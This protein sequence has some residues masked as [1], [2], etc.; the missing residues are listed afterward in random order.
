MFQ[1]QFC[2]YSNCSAHHKPTPEHFARHGFY[3]PKCRHTPVPRFRCRTCNR[4]YSRQSFRMDFRDHKPH[5]NV[6]LVKLL[7]S[8]VGLRQSARILSMSRRCVALK[9]RKICDHAAYLN[10]NLRRPFRC[11]VRLQMDE[12]ET[13]ETKRR[14]RPVTF[15][16]L[17]EA[18]SRFTIWGE[19]G[20]LRPKGKMTDRRRLAIEADIREFGERKDTS[21][22]TV[23]RTLRHAIPLVKHLLTLRVQ[24]DEKSTYP[25]LLK[26]AFGSGRIR[27]ETTSSKQ[28]RTI[29]NPLFPI[30][31]TEAIARDLNGRLRRESWLVSKQRKFL[32]QAFQLYMAWKNY[33]RPR[34]NRDWETPA[35]IAGIIKRRLRPGDLV[36]WRQDFGQRKLPIVPLAA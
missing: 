30:N 16:I 17:I 9:A 12:I 20:T 19:S 3:K 28:E 10:Q 1:P 2:P 34:F 25:G 32:D 31:Q 7:M 4:T 26:A 18:N 21:K 36:G 22:E 5:Q 14:E 24:T 11:E 8:G 27:H 15:P 6:P 23:R 35:M 13:Y 33:V 29:K